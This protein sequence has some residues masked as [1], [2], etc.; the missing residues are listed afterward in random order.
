[1][2]DGWQHE[3]P[4]D[5]LSLR[6]PLGIRAAGSV[7]PISFGGFVE[8]IGRDGDIARGIWHPSVTL[9]AV[10]Y[11][12]PMI[13]W[14]G[15]HANTLRLWSARSRNPIHLDRFNRGSANNH[16]TESAGACLRRGSVST[17]LHR[18]ISL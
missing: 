15:R 11:D 16:R 17:A 4:E 12:T 6:Q 7:V 9:Q 3:V 14:R 1:M 18:K 8:Y 13:G 5:W 2:I 10:A